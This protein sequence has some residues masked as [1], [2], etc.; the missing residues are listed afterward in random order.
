VFE[1]VSGHSEKN[2]GGRPQNSICKVGADFEA[3]DPHRWNTDGKEGSENQFRLKH[4]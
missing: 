3:T 4:L 1:R 2:N